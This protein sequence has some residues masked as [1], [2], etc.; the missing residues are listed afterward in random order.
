MHKIIRNIEH[1]AKN[2]HRLEFELSNNCQY[3]DAHKWCPLSR[4]ERGP[5]FLGSK[6]VHKVVDFFQRFDFYG[7][8]YLSG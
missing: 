2:I 4:D 3:S 7:I 1:Q 6:I 8:V 5:V